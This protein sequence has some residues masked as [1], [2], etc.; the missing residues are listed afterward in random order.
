MNI[1]T[2]LMMIDVQLGMFDETFPVY[3]GEALLG[4]VK[5]LLGRARAANY[6]PFTRWDGLQ[7]LIRQNLKGY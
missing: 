3:N 5:K 6:G 1:D 2:A 4:T 7:E